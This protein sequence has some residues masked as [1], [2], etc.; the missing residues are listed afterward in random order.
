MST[1]VQ[2]VPVFSMPAGD[3]FRG[4]GDPVGIDGTWH[5][6]AAEAQAA[7]REAVAELVAGDERVYDAHAYADVILRVLGL[8]GDL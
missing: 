6:L 8:G 4:A 7:R 3:L 2:G 5:S 1:D